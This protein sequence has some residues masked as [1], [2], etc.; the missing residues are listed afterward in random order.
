[1]NNWAEDMATAKPLVDADKAEGE[2][3]G[4]SGT[5]ALF[6]NG[7]AY[8]GPSHPKYLKMWIDEQLAKAI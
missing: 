7:R 4:V 3:S 1:M 6:I 5:P 8:E 2:K